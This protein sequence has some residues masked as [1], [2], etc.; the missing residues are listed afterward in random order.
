VLLV[1][2]EDAVRTLSR[3]IL[4]SSGYTVLE[5]RDGQEGVWVAQQHP[6]PIHLLVT[7]LVMPRLSGRRLADLLTEARP[8]LR[9]LFLSGYLH[10]T[11]LQ[12]GVPA[13][14]VALLQKPFSPISLARKVREVLD[15]KEH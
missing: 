8:H 7:D 3:L 15:A 13:A 12:H 9:V 11:T 6:G 4:Q 5:A 2:D 1:E 14:G 10:E